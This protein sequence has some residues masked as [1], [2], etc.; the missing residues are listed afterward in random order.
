MLVSVILEKLS[1]ETRK[2]LAREHTDGEWTFPG[3]QDAVLKE[4]HVFE[5]MLNML[6]L[7][8]HAPTDCKGS[9]ACIDR[10]VVCQSSRR[11]GIV[12]QQN[13]C[14]NCLAQHKRFHSVPQETDAVSVLGST[15]PVYVTHKHVC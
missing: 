4:I 11:L 15:M 8:S 14:F 12:W 9:H 13:M 7:S 6:F 2:H 5:S 1:D 10:E 3:L